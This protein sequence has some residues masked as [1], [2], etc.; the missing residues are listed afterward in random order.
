REA[1]LNA[2]RHSGASRIE[3]EVEH[4]PQRLRIVVR[5]NG[6]GIDREVLRWGRAGH[7]GLS[8]MCERAERMGARLHV[9]SGV[10]AGTEIELS[11]HSHIA[12]QP[13]S[14]SKRTEA[15]APTK[16]TDK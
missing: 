11:V 9:R 4:A 15:A 1:L 2:L 8:G 6:Y 5:D 10:R 16:E 7:W 13:P 12:F 14:F 3:V